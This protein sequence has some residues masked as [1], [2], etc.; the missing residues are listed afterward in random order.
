MS[1]TDSQAVVSVVAA[2]AIIAGLAGVVLLAA[3]RVRWTG[4]LPF[5]PFLVLGT[6]ATLVLV[7][8]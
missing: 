8:V 2:L 6:A 1:L 3:R 5:G 7:T 4:H